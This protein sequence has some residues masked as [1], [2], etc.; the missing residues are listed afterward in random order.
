MFYSI[1]PHK[2]SLSWIFLL[3]EVLCGVKM[4]TSTYTVKKENCFH[5]SLKDSTQRFQKR[6]L[7]TGLYHISVGT[8]TTVS[9]ALF[10]LLILMS[11]SKIFILFS[12]ASALKV[13]IC[14]LLYHFFCLIV[15]KLLYTCLI[16]SVL[17][18]VLYVYDWKS[19]TILKNM[20]K[21]H[22]PS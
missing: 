10:F 3:A 2:T 8:E 5:L 7:S 17:V 19:Y 12:K 15:K 9:S 13:L 22:T 20:K 14:N 16:V 21:T 18:S 6:L 1:S 11:D 4:L